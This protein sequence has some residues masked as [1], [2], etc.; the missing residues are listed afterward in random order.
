M[1][2]PAPAGAPYR[3]SMLFTW[4]STSFAIV[5]LICSVAALRLSVLAVKNSQEACAK[6]EERIALTPSQ[7]DLLELQSEFTNHVDTVAQLNDN[8]KKL[9]SRIG[10]REHRDRKNGADPQPANT[11]EL[12]RQLRREVLTRKR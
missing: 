5:A 9:R 10:M 3:F 1:S 6:A 4:L 8:L 2:P 11:E 12:K 7:T